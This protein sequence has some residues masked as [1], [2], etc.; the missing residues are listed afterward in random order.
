M[1]EAVIGCEL[2]SSVKNIVARLLLMYV[3]VVT[4]SEP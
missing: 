2:F 1:K 4:D 3:N